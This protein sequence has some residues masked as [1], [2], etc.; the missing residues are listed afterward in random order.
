ME[1]KV[2]FYSDGVRLAGILYE[3]DTAVDKSCPGIVLCQG[4]TGHKEYFWFPQ[5]AQQFADL[6]WV[7]LIWDYR[8]VGESGGPPR[9]FPM[10]QAKDIRSALTFLEIHPKVDPEKL[11]L[12]GWSYGAGMIPYVAAVDQRV[13]CSVAVGGWADGY[14]WIRDLRRLWEWLELLDR[15]DR[16]R[17]ARV[18]SAES[19]AF[20]EG[21]I[22]G[23]VMD[24]TFSETQQL[25][26]SRIPGMEKAGSRRTFVAEIEKM[27][28]FRPIEVVDRISP[29]AIYYIVAGRDTRCPAQHVID[30][31]ERTK[32]PRKLWAIPD[33]GHYVIYEEPYK[34]QILE[35]S[36]EY[37]TEHLH[38]KS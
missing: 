1:R 34:T 22:W 30:M 33:A 15:I 2:S 7:A 19:E 38:L 4:G 5:T 17:K 14:R 26:R 32:E 6:G 16:D 18:L 35:S 12:I 25:M 13:K 27:L 11:A 24:T 36:I 3:P 8:G 9:L 28:E 10:E 21:M 20:P 29:R 37:L 23:Q 31:Y